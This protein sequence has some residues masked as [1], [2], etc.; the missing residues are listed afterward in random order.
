VRHHQSASPAAG[1]ALAS[2]AYSIDEKK[3]EDKMRKMGINIM[4][5]GVS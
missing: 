4:V 3:D 2:F 5:A 1:G